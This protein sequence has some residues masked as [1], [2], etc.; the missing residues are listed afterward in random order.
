MIGLR[1]F[2]FFC[3]YPSCPA[4]MM[5]CYPHL[6]LR[7][8]VF[9]EAILEVGTSGQRGYSQI[10]ALN[11]LPVWGLYSTYARAAFVFSHRITY[12]PNIRSSESWPVLSV[13]KTIYLIF[14]RPVS[15]IDA[16]A[17]HVETMQ[18]L[19]HRCI[20]HSKSAQTAIT[21]L[22]GRPPETPFSWNKWNLELV[23]LPTLSTS[24]YYRIMTDSLVPYNETYIL[25]I[26]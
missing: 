14:P 8:E 21:D 22:Q 12:G 6:V 11:F 19:L 20:C 13:S 3:D 2:F 7:T 9:N 16:S 23:R 4:S 18:L 24:C 1:F 26:T 17:S 5:Q 15:P 25:Y 10:I